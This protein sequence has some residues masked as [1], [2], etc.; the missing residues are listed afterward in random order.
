[1]NRPSEAITR[2]TEYSL[3][4]HLLHDLAGALLSGHIKIVDLTAPLGPNTPV[5]SLPPEVGKST[6]PVSIH[7]ISSYDSDGPSWCWNWVEI[8]EH[9]GTH[10]DAPRHWIT[11]RD[12]A[13]NT[14]DRIPVKN[15]VA[16]AC[17]IDRS[18]E[19][20]ADSDYLLTVDSIQAWERENGEIDAGSWVLLRT[21]W[22]KRIGSIESFIN[23]DDQGSHYPG[24]T[25]EAIE[26][27]ISKNIV[28]WGTDTISTDAGGAARMTP[29]FPAHHL[30]HKANRYGLSGLCHLDQLPAKGAVIIAAPLK[31]IDGT[32]SPVRALAFVA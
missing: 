3:N 22:S 28:G 30:M 5:K 13:D 31:F 11:G 19:A 8:G 12:H 24:P 4:Q 6:P 26:Y 2:F 10:F 7:K 15:F 1:M 32:G 17:V 25:P 27:L 9:T 21:D 16:P 23:S 20:A 14:T 29:Q 18:K